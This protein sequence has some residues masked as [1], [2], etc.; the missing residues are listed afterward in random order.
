MKRWFTDTSVLLKRYVMEPGSDW[1]RGELI[2]YRLVISHLTPIEM[3]A[4]L[5]RRYQQGVISRFAFYQARRAFMKHYEAGVYQVIDWQETLFGEAMR[6]TF[7]QG[8]R[9]YDAVQLAAAL[10]ASKSVERSRF[11]FLTADVALEKVAQA[12]GLATENPLRH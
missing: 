3:T 11:T 8:L 2:R 7:R 12:E 10:L 5:G 4:A 6:L 9:A 1:F